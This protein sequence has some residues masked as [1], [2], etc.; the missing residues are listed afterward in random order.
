M[1]TIVIPAFNEQRQIRGAVEALLAQTYPKDHLDI[2]VAS[3]A[4]T[5]GTDAIV[6]EYASHGV[7]LLRMPMRG[8]KTAAENAVCARIRGEIVVNSD[9]SIRLHPDAVRN[10]VRRMSDPKVGVASGR[11]VSVAAGQG[12]ANVTEAGYVGYEM[13]LRALETKVDGIVGASGSCY[14]IRADLHRIPIRQDLSR[15]FSAA[16]TARVHGYRAVSADDALCYVPRTQSLKREYLRKV[17]TIARGMETLF[18]NRRLLDPMQYGLF[19]WMLF[20][21]KLGRWLVPPAALCCALGL[22]LL[23]PTHPLAAL[24][25][26]CGAT[27]L[28]VAALGAMWPAHKPMPRVVSLIAFGVAANLAV[29]HAA[30]R[31]ARGREDHI[32][33]PTRREPTLAAQ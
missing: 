7:E 33:E 30:V 1:V 16:L 9:A 32:W 21:H 11:D 14:A 22:S 17:R 25:L 6:A 24:L 15:D 29:L 19:A 28:I 18:E 12:T 26:A 27:T 8:G 3:D 4:S 13:W 23:A 2:V 10:L 20:S 5:D 31:V